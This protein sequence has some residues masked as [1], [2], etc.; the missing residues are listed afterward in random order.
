MAS[1]YAKRLQ[2]LEELLASKLN[3]PLA[4]VWINTGET[5]EQACLRAGY[6][7][8]QASRIK[9]CR[10]MTP[11]E[12]AAAAPPP[13]DQPHEPDPPEE[14]PTRPD[15]TAAELGRLVSS[16]E[17]AERDKGRVQI[18]RWLPREEA[19]A[20]GIEM[21]SN[22]PKPQPQ[23]PGPPELKLLPPPAPA[24]EPPQPTTPDSGKRGPLTEEQMRKL[25]ED[26]DR[27]FGR[28]IKY[29]RIGLA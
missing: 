19:S 20:R 24:E 27:T 26:R 11:E 12:A 10:W 14:A 3:K 15:P 5:R 23:L 7:P 21:P 2:K 18:W 22:P 4:F 28:P 1:T 25:L 13:W 9:F 8:S 16:G 6:D 29:P 17:I